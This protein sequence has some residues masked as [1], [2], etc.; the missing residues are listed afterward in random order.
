VKSIAL[1]LLRHGRIGDECKAILRC[2]MLYLSEVAD[3]DLSRIR[4]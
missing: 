2:L 1:I 3:I 4:W